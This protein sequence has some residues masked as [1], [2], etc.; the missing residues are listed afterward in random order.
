MPTHTTRRLHACLP[1]Q[2]PTH[3][4]GLP[5]AG[6]S[7]AGP[8]AQGQGEG[9]QRQ[10]RR[11]LQNAN[12]TGSAGWRQADPW[13]AAGIRRAVSGFFSPMGRGNKEEACFEEGSIDD[14]WSRRRRRVSSLSHPLVIRWEMDTHTHTHIHTHTRT[15]THTDTVTRRHDDTPPRL[16]RSRSL[17]G[18]RTGGWRAGGAHA[19][20]GWQIRPT[21]DRHGHLPHH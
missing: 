2:L 15:H 20:A 3:G 18:W 12:E 16:P 9:Q 17:A 19:S 5:R 10:Q 21:D 1:A 6:C 4:H 13:L 11:S 14:E 7:Q 8:K